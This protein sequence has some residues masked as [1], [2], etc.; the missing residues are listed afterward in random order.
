M[1]TQAKTLSTLRS[2]RDLQPSVTFQGRHP[3]FTTQCCLPW[4]HLYL[5]DE[6][7]RF[8]REV[9]VPRQANT[10]EKVAAFPA[11]GAGLALTGKANP[12]TFM[13]ALG[14][15]DLITFDLVGIPAPQRDGPLRSVQRLLKRNH[16]VGF[17]VAP[18][19]GTTLALPEWTAPKSSLAPA[20]EKRFEEIAK[21]RSAKFEIDSASIAR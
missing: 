12:L 21:P 19:F 11:A 1:T 5:V 17:D 13:H 9:G 18:A 10:Q 14:N 4:R 15:F 7:V 20:A 6:I 8:E 2:R 16:D 3:Q